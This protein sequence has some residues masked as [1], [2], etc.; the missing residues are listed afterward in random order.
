MEVAL[1]I[2]V[3]M[4]LGGGLDINLVTQRG[5]LNIGQFRVLEK[6]AVATPGSLYFTYWVYRSPQTQKPVRVEQGLLFF[7]ERSG[8]KMPDINIGQFTN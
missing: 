7:K 8:G 6:R 4:L 5:S 3:V 2:I 1:I